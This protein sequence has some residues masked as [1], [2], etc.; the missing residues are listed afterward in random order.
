M[1]AI[2]PPPVT[3]ETNED[4]ATKLD[5]DHALLALR[6]AGLPRLPE[7][8]AASRGAHRPSWLGSLVSLAVLGAFS[9]AA[10]ALVG[11]IITSK[12]S[13]R[14]IERWPR[15]VWTRSSRT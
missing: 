4:R 14:G 1:S 12:R 5:N 3:M 6:G 7:R 2:A 8:R 13:K 9:V 11:R 15:L 10:A